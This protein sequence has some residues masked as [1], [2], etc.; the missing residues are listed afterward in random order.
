[1]E[2]SLQ[3]V[4]KLYEHGYLTYP[5]TNSEYLACAEKDKIRKIIANVGNL[6]YPVEFKDGKT[7]FDDTK[8]E[9]H[10]ALTPTYKIPAKS[11][12]AEEEMLVYQTV[13]RRFVAV[14]CSEECCAQKTEI[15]IGVGELEQFVLRGT[16]ILE[17]GWTRFDDSSQKDKLL[18]AL[19]K[20]DR[21]NIDFKPKEKETSPPKHRIG[22]K[23]LTKFL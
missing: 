14:F 22:F 2:R 7:I 19:E 4:Q 6:G 23:S 3:I 8:I 21:V 10:S 13:F 5:R 20:G 9:S 1:M 15:T 18:P 12:L 11:A 17:P 16:V